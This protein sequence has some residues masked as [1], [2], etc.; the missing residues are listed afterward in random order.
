MRTSFL[1]NDK[2]DSLFRYLINHP[3]E[4][5]KVRSI[6]TKLGFA[7][8][9]VSVFLKSLRKEGLVK[10]D[11]LDSGSP[12]LRSWKILLNI[13]AI[14]PHLNKF[15]KAIGAKGIGLYGSCSDGTDTPESDLDLWVKTDLP[16]SDIAIAKA[17]SLLREATGREISVFIVTKERIISLQKTDP[18]LYCSLT[19]SFHLWGEMLN[20]VL[21]DKI[22][23]KTSS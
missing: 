1:S 5:L 18:P 7:P 6:A 23:K 14:S 11:S 4:P 9:F 3:Q 15:A 21:A 19:H 17:K 20:Q 10:N 16:P 22:P 8:S 12:E 13:Q 2:R